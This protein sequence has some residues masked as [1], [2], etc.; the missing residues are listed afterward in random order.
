MG[1]IFHSIS[2]EMPK[3][4]S[5]FDTI[6]SRTR[7]KAYAAARPSKRWCRAAAPQLW[8]LTQDDVDENVSPVVVVT[9]KKEFLEME[10]FTVS[11][12][13]TVSYESEDL[14]DEST[15]EEGFCTF[16][17]GGSPDLF[18]EPSSSGSAEI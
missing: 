11:C 15:I 8:D 18:A 10:E 4:L 12:E 7:S 1:E 6:A 5:S 14:Y 3:Y 2:E 17:R 16:V 9:V 13:S